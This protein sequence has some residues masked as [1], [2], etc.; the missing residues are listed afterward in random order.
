MSKMLLAE[1]NYVVETLGAVRRN[2]E[3]RLT[4]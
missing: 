4:D 1:D 3:E 2:D